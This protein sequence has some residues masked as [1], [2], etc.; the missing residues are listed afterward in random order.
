[1]NSL[2]KYRLIF[3]LIALILLTL[4]Q[5]ALALD[6]Q[7]DGKPVPAEQYA[8]DTIWVVVTAVL[9]FWM[10][11]GFAMVESG[12]TRAKNA[13]NILMKNLMDFSMGSVAFWLFGFGLMFGNGNGFMGLS[14]FFAH[15]GTAADYSALSWTSVPVLAAWFFQLVFA[16][17]A[18]TIVSGAMAER[19]KFSAYLVYSFV[20]SLLIYPI[21]GHWIWGGGWLAEKGF[22]D[23]AGSTV[24]HSVGGWMA[25]VGAWVLG[26]RIGKYAADGRPRPLPGHNIPIAALGVFILWMGWF[27][28]NPG[29]TMAANGPGIANTAVTTNIAAAMGATM[30]MI[31]VWLKLGKPDIGMTLNGA[32]AGLVAITAPCYFVTPLGG[33]IIGAAAG[34]IVVLAVL[35]FDAI[36]IDDPV[37]AISVHGVCGAFGTLCVGLFHTEQGVFYAADKAAAFHFLGVQALGVVAVMGSCLV[38]GTALFLAIKHAIGLR[39]SPEEE[40]EGLD[41]GEHGASAYP[42]FQLIPDHTWGPVGKGTPAAAPEYARKAEEVPA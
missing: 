10:Q 26:P 18:A 20:I 38:A 28:F 15:S 41:L 39:V 8:L 11:A 23:F 6:G 31:T 21:I 2:R 14:G 34:V 17:T 13:V 29:S 36:H 35:F 16:A 12:F 30:A 4:P 37:G 19:T 1:V 7:I 9:V 3:G 5:V 42:G 22:L 32:L 24:V 27:G 40:L 33:A 25:L